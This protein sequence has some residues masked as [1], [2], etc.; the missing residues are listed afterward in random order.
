MYVLVVIAVCLTVS[1]ALSE[2]FYRLK[3]PRILGQIFAGILLGIPVI[4][5]SIFIQGIAP[6]ETLAE[7]GVI[8]L[9]LLVGLEVDYKKFKK[10][11]DEAFL[12]ALFAAA[13]PFL[14]GFGLIKFLGYSNMVAVVTGICLAITAPETIIKSLI[15]MKKLKS[16]VGEI[17]MP[18][19][20]I[21][22]F[23]GVS[24]LTVVLVLVHKESSS[25]LTLLPVKMIAFIVIV[26]GLF[27]L[28]PLLV[29]YI[30]EEKSEISDFTTIIILALFIS[31][32]SAF[33][34]LGTIIGA[35]IAG[36]IIQFVIK[37]K[38]EEKVLVKDLKLITFG[39]II[40]FFF[41]NVGL[42]INPQSI[43][44][45]PTLLVLI[46]IVAI[47]GKVLGSM[48]VSIFTKLKLRQATL[49]GWGMNSRGALEIVVAEIAL[50]AGLLP[51]SI[52]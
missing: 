39:L 43:I 9:M 4:R 50:S 1:F 51:L 8:F 35:F 12:V 15:E 19:A 36:F 25:Q 2:L 21:D 23:I 29:S 40:P 13:L 44:F 49:I 10:F 30:Q 6:I 20:M 31:V 3:Y 52:Y 34:G 27:K 7:I 22:D 46:I 37:D 48:S 33:L 45:N 5:N 14:L 28:I 47:L 17:L 18:A 32:I 41:I 26:Y 24:L 11:S 42:K 16:K 38:H